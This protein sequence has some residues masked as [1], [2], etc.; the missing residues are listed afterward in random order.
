MEIRSAYVELSVNDG[1]TMRAWVARP[2]EEGAYPALLVFQ[3]AFGVNAHIRDIAGRFA[4]EGFVA[5]APEL[6][7]RTAAGF[8]GRYDDFP[9]AVP[10][11]K[12]LNDASMGADLRAAHDWV[13]GS[14]GV[15]LPIFAIGYCMGGRAAFL[16]ALTLPLAGAIS[17]YG[18]G[19]APNATNPGLLG[20]ASGIQAPLLLFWGGRDKHIPPEQVRAVTDA[21]RAAGKNFVN[22]EIS[23]ADHAFF[24]DARASYSP[25]AALL[26]WPLTLA[27]LRARSG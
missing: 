17:Y 24:C 26:A 6:F 23:N 25:A 14:M 12:A 20:R 21:L 9:S 27:F 1:T 7:H 8:D 5:V 3:E 13:R 18:G 22:V 15:E 4:R 2:K 16:A 10:H 19:I 11:M